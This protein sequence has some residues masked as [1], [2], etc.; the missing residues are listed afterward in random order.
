MFNFIIIK[1]AGQLISPE[2]DIA[3]ISSRIRGES[4]QSGAEQIADEIGH[5]PGRA[6]YSQHA[7]ATP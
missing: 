6:A 5:Q 3:G 1:P 2:G 7:Q 4:E